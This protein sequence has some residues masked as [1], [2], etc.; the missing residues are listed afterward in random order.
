MTR[1]AIAALAILACASLAINATLWMAY[2][3]TMD[4]LAES[5]IEL[6]AHEINQEAVNA[7]IKIRDAEKTLAHQRAA[8]RKDHAARVAADNPDWTGG[9]LPD[10]VLRLFPSGEG[11]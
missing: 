2:R 9:L 10:A 4:K 8:E 3:S 1:W 6:A 7:A 5:Q 11:H